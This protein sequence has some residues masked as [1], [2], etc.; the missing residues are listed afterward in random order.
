[1]GPFGMHHRFSRR[2]TIFV[3][4]FC[5]VLAL[6]AAVMLLWNAILPDIAPVSRIHYGQALGLLLLCRIL[7]GGFRFGGRGG[8][9]PFAHSNFREKWKNMSEEERAELKAKWRGRQNRF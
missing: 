9:P 4:I 8:R 6:G 3:F 1:M 2:G 7:F 5:M